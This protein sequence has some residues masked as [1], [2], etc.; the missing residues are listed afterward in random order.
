MV[1]GDAVNTAARVQVAAEPGSVLVDAPTQRLAGSAIGFAE[2]G[3]FRMKGKGQPEGLWR[4]TPVLAGAGGAQRV[5]GLEAPLIG[6]DAELRTV[7]RIRN[8]RA[9]VAGGPGRATEG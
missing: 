6:R 7:A 3:S 5:D 4:A 8:E 2:A 9:A 1:A